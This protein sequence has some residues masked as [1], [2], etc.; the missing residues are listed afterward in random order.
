MYKS[1]SIF[2]SLKKSYVLINTDFSIKDVTDTVLGKLNL[3]REQILKMNVKDLPANGNITPVFSETGSVEFLLF[4][5][6]SESLDRM[7]KEFLSTAS[8]ELKTPLTALKLQV[9]LAKKFINNEDAETL[10]PSKM[11]KFLER[12]NQDV[13][14]LSQ[15]VDDMLM[16]TVT[17]EFEN[18]DRKSWFIL[19]DFMEVFV[20]RAVD[21]F[22]D[23]KERVEIRIAA[24]EMVFWN[25]TEIE[26][27]LINLLSNAFRFGEGSKI[28]LTVTTGGGKAYLIVED[29]GPGIS[30]DDEKQI[31]N[32]FA[33]GKTRQSGFGLGLYNCKK[34]VDAHSGKI[35]FSKTNEKGARFEVCLPLKHALAIISCGK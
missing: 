6:N 32:L 8:H 5:L 28:R 9:Q 29:Q 11:K 17:N 12:A 21:T 19:Q 27:I 26:Q 2:R 35:S 23:F 3:E 13:S 18:H 30:K 4:E 15:I 34:I 31:F 24:P 20:V 7:R 33:K 16:A 22:K 10:S 14:R 1:Q 25:R